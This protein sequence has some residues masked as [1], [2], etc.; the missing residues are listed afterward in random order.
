M[1]MKNLKLTQAEVAERLGKSR[2]YIA[3]YLRLLTLPDAVKAMVQKQSM[4]MG[5]HGRY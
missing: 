3:N 5:Q 1:L 4:S 2:P